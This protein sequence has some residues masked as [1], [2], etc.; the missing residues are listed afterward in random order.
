MCL[1]VDANK[2]LIKVP[3]PVRPIAAVDAPPPYSTGKHRAETVP[4]ETHCLVTDVDA[5]SVLV[6]E[7]VVERPQDVHAD[8]YR[9]RHPREVVDGLP[10]PAKRHPSWLQYFVLR[11]VRHSRFRIPYA[12][13][14]TFSL[15]TD[16]RRR[17]LPRRPRRNGI[18]RP[19]PGR[20]ALQQAAARRPALLPPCGPCS[21]P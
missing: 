4:P 16:P 13:A 12:E 11:S 5:A 6:D 9:Q 8:Q 7:M 10:E 19:K 15:C 20:K 17:T 18:H 14:T 1:T 3:A 2:P 21:T